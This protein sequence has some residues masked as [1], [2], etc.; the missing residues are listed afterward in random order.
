MFYINIIFSF[1]IFI[2]FLGIIVILCHFHL[3]KFSYL[4]Y[5]FMFILIFYI[6]FKFNSKENITI[7]CEEKKIY[8]FLL[9]NL[10]Y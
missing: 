7:L 9:K 10:V 4:F 5:F 1:I 6:E 3:M 8:E 2:A